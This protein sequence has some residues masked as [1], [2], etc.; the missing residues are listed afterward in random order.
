[1]AQS[2]S[3]L[4]GPSP[5]E[6]EYAKR[7]EEEKLARQEYRDRLSTAGQGL[8]MYAGVARSG[9]RQGE[10]LRKLRLFGESPSPAMEKAAT[11]REI[12]GSVS[13]ED[14]NNPETLIKIS[15]ELSN[16]GYPNEAFQLADRAKQI[17]TEAETSEL[18]RIQKE[19]A[20]A[21]KEAALAKSAKGKALSD[22]LLGKTETQAS[23]VE[24]STWLLNNFEDSFSG[25]ANRFFGE[26]GIAITKMLPQS[27]EDSRMVAWWQSYA[28]RNNKV[29][30][31]LFGSALTNVE[32][33]EFE[34][35]IVTPR[36]NAGVARDNLEKQAK[37]I[38][39]A[40]IKEVN[41]LKSQGK[42]ISGLIEMAPSIG[43]TTTQ[44]EAIIES[45]DLSPLLSPEKA[46]LR[47]E[48][49]ESDEWGFDSVVGEEQNG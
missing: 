26:T 6:L 48:V 28:D 19:L 20:I 42:D 38:R 2:I 11:I 29:R 15:K 36:M 45:G 9:V 24:E 10:Q 7:Q 22:K 4:F 17:K 18:T 34:K 46:N 3:S 44:L 41:R 13:Q 16:R 40:F 21:Q 31:E 30:K 1:M 12:I 39:S 47:P 8:G 49:M 25:P 33:K 5:E 35:F 43:V 37:A 14:L 32:R 23:G 27:D